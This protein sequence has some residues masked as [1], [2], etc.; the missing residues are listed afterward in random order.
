LTDEM[1]LIFA[2]GA[3]SLGAEHSLLILATD[4]VGFGSPQK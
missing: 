3:V 4:A 1:L 2:T